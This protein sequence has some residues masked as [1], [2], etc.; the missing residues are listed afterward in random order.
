MERLRNTNR[1][2]RICGLK[3]RP[4]PHGL[5][6]GIR[7]VQAKSMCLQRKLRLDMYVSRGGLVGRTQP[8]DEYRIDLQ[9]ARSKTAI[10][11]LLH[12]IESNHANWGRPERMPRECAPDDVQV[13]GVLVVVRDRE[14]LSHTCRR[15]PHRGVCSTGEGG[16]FKQLA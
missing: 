16:Q 13:D 11:S 3:C 8:D 1:L 10:G 4:H 7:A 15:R 9:K 14:S 2:I 5:P 12:R 6:G